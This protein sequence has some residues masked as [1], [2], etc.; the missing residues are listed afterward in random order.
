MNALRLGLVYDRGGEPAVLYLPDDDRAAH[1]YVI[2]STGVGKSKARASWALDDLGDGRGFGIIDPDGDLIADVL[3][4]ADRLERIRL[5]EFGGES[6]VT[7]NPL[8]PLPG[9]DIFSQTL[10]LV[11]VFRKIWALSDEGAPRLLEILRNSIWT[12]IEG[13]QT[14]LELEALLVNDRFRERMLRRL[15]NAGV[16]SFWRDR[17]ARWSPSV[18]TSNIESTLNKVS[19]FASDPR[20]RLLLGAQRSTLNLRELMDQ[21]EVLLIDVSK[22]VLRTNTHLV[23]ALF[24]SR[25]QMAAQARLLVPLEERTPWHLYVDEFQNYATDSFAELLSEARKMGL[26]LILA[27]QTLAQ[28]PT[29]LRAIVLGNAKSLVTFRLDRKDAEFLAHYMGDIDPWEIKYTLGDRVTFESIGEQWEQLNSKLAALPARSA[30]L[31]TK[32]WPARPF[33]TLELDD[34]PRQAERNRER[35]RYLGL[36][37]GWLRKVSELDEE[38][39]VRAV[40]MAAMDDEDPPDFWASPRGSD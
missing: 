33:Q 9:V 25:L 12:L 8:E 29:Q 24:L 15:T 30:L 14:L 22:G 40:G 27:H 39:A 11:E 7:L 17:Y 4:H 35:V 10:E 21:A 16:A 13:G 34:D 6:M 2:G 1:L 23:G 20:L 31:R 36:Q 3:A 37:S 19:T 32:G 18:R 28:L 38:L 5:V 26:R